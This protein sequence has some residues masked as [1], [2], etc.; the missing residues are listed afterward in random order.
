MCSLGNTRPLAIF[1]IVSANCPICIESFCM[2]LEH[3]VEPQ[4]NYALLQFSPNH[5][6]IQYLY[7]ANVWIF[8]NAKL[9]LEACPY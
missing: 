9:V 3:D 7:Y 1:T 6:F 5:I 8:W 4:I 2:E